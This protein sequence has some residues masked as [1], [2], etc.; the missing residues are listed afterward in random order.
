MVLHLFD[1]LMKPE[2]WVKSES[3]SFTSE[4][5]QRSFWQKFLTPSPPSSLEQ[6]S[7]KKRYA[8]CGK[9]RS[10]FALRS[11]EI[12]AICGLEMA[13]SFVL[14]PASKTKLAE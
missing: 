8:F 7:P 2:C 13:C 10:V 11:C 9:N 5:I 1:L 14:L 3:C 12:L 4:W 6:A